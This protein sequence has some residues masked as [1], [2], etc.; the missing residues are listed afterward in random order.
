MPTKKMDVRSERKGSTGT[1]NGGGRP[2]ALMVALHWP[3]LM[4]L[5]AWLGPGL[6]QRGKRFPFAYFR[7]SSISLPSFYHKLC[8]IRKPSKSVLGWMQGGRCMQVATQPTGHP[9]QPS[10]NT[11][12]PAT[13]HCPTLFARSGPGWMGAAGCSASAL[14]SL[15]FIPQ[16]H[17]VG[18]LT[19]DYCT[20]AGESEET[21]VTPSQY[22]AMRPMRGMERMDG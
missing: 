4:Q 2:P 15:I 1:I 13:A 18:T 9:I 8:V 3:Q 6:V 11:T 5:S 21:S 17:L 20:E 7:Q 10:P 19:T 16:W 12:Y 14:P 22:H